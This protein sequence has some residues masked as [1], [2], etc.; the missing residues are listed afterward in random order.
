MMNQLISALPNPLGDIRLDAFTFYY[1]MEYLKRNKPRVLYF[2]FDE[3]DDFAHSGEYGAYL[4]A[5]NYTDRF[6]G[7]LWSYLQADP[8]YKDKTTLLITCDHGRGDNAEDWKHHGIKIK[9]A[10]QIW[11]AVLGPDTPALGEVKEEMQL[12][13]NQ[14]AKT[15]AGFLGLDFTTSAKPGEAVTHMMNPKPTK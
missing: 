4:N 11:F 6:I 5:A 14:L 9:D 10:D 12:Y 1:G 15:L 3:T 2:A 8:Q 13:Q 7:E